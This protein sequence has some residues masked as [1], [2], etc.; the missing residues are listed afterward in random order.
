MSL[1]NFL[2]CG[3]NAVIERINVAIVFYGHIC[4]FHCLPQLLPS[5]IGMFVFQS[6]CGLKLLISLGVPEAS[7]SLKALEPQPNRSF[8]A[9]EAKSAGIA[10]RLNFRGVPNRVNHV[11]CI[12]IQSANNSLRQY[13]VPKRISKLCSHLYQIFSG[14]WYSLFGKFASNL[15]RKRSNRKPFCLQEIA[16][17][18]FPGSVLSAHPHDNSAQRCVHKF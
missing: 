18:R 5:R 3:S 17:S 13:T 11:I 10:Q 6:V 8:H 7:T 4:K 16:N 15:V 2:N 9:H 14:F 12:V 1:R